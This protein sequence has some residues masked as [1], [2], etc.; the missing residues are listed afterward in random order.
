MQTTTRKTHGENMAT[1]ARNKPGNTGITGGIPGINNVVPQHKT[2]TAKQLQ[3][4]LGANEFHKTGKWSAKKPVGVVGT[5]VVIEKAPK[6]PKTGNSIR[7]CI[8]KSNP[9]KVYFVK[10]GSSAPYYFG[11]VSI[12][13]IPKSMP[14]RPPSDMIG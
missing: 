13:R 8:L 4:V 2:P 10:S 7:A 14:P 6:P 3:A 9:D 12:S 5:E 11:P 1:V